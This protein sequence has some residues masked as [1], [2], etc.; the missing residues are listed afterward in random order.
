MQK[1]YNYKDNIKVIS[2][3]FFYF[4]PFAF[5]LSSGFFNFYFMLNLILGFSC[6]FILKKKII[7]DKSDLLLL[8]FF[9]SVIISSFL[10]VLTSKNYEILLKSIALIRFFLLFLLLRN[11]FFYRLI[12]L[13]KISII[14]FFSSLALG[15]DLI[16]QHIF[17]KDIFGY[18]PFHDRYAGFFNY[19][20]I[21]GSYL[22]KFL[23]L[24]SLFLFFLKR[25][26]VLIIFFFIFFTIS[27]ILSIDKLPFLISL[28]IIILYA[29]LINKRFLFS[30]FFI[31]L[32]F[33]TIYN[34]H[35][36]INDRYKNFFDKVKFFISSNLSNKQFIEKNEIE[37]SNELTIYH[38]YLFDGYDSIFKSSFILISQNF[39]IGYGHKSFQIL[40]CKEHKK[41][42]L[43]CT[44]HPH[45]IYLEIMI[46]SGIV[47]LIFFIFFILRVFVFLLKNKNEKIFLLFLIIAIVELFPIRPY[48]SIF[49]TINGSI[50]WFLIALISL[51][52]LKK[53]YIISN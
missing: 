19:E 1:V 7:F 18:Y 14:F 20:A 43:R 22:Q 23:I 13:E 21:A 9:S 47:G 11:F 40:T 49:T 15:L 34:Y 38:K 35:K 33:F 8:L 12:E 52:K 39:F 26:V 2:V 17:G 3:I 29:F 53:K 46:T 42:N 27:I 50:F 41:E 37:K 32:F 28:I 31:F 25:K 24:S 10:N 36:V 4:F 44:T 30:I 16:I 51:S 48:G 5:F 45:N 6:L